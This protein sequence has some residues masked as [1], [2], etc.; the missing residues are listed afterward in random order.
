MTRTLTARLLQRLW[1]ILLPL[2]A[3]CGGV[4]FLFVALIEP[5]GGLGIFETVLRMTP[6]IGQLLGS[7]EID[8]TTSAGIA[9]IA[10]VH[11]FVAILMAAWPLSVAAAALGGDVE[12]GEADLLLSRAVPR[13]AMFQAAVATLL[14]GALAMCASLWLGT[15]LAQ[16]ISPPEDPMPLGRFA[17]AAVVNAVLIASTGGVLLLLSAGS[18]ERGRILATGAG[19]WLLN[20]FAGVVAPLFPSLAFL[21]LYSLQGHARPQAVIASGQI[22]WPDTGVLL[23]VGVAGLSAAALVWSRRDVRS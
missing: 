17:A 23:T 3:L 20:F 16:W 4:A 9:S 18:S 7:N 1:P 5:M 12:S 13:R 8:P 22:P 2:S 15:A 10:Y 19:L 6:R 21:R 14:A 11:P